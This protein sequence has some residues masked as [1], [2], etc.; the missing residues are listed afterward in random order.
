MTVEDEVILRAGLGMALAVALAALGQ[1]WWGAE[2]ARE[3]PSWMMMGSTAAGVV[4]LFNLA[5]WLRIA[6]RAN[7][8][9]RRAGAGLGW[10]LVGASGAWVALDVSG[11]A[12]S[13]GWVAG[14]ARWSTPAEGGGTAGMKSASALLLF[15]TA[16]AGCWAGAA[17]EGI[18]WR[19]RVGLALSVAAGGFSLAVAIVQAAGADEVF[20][21]LPWLSRFWCAV[22]ILALNLA[23]T[24]ELG[25]WSG[26]ARLALGEAACEESAARRRE[27]RWMILGSLAA[28][29][30]LIALAFSYLDA[31][32]RE[33]REATTRALAS[34]AE[35]QSGALAVWLRERTGDAR[36]LMNSPGLAERL[37]EATDPSRPSGAREVFSRQLEGYRTFYGYAA[38]VVFDAEFRPQ[39]R[40]LD[41]G[42]PVP[43]IDAD[44]QRAVRAA[45]DVVA[46]DIASSG[47]GQVVMDFIVPVRGGSGGFAGAVLLRV[48]ARRS[49]FPFLRSWPEATRTG[50]VMLL[51]REGEVVSV[52]NDL[53][54]GAAA[55][56][57]RVPMS[58]RER[59][60]VQAVSGRRRGLIKA[61]DHRGMPVV[62]LARSVE[63]APW[64]LLVKLD[65][66]EAYAE[67]RHRALEMIGGFGFGSVLL[68]LLL[69]LAW[70]RRERRHL[71]AQIEAERERQAL[72]RRHGLLMQRTTDGILLLDSRMR[73]AEANGRASELYGYGGDG[74]VGLSARDLRAAA[75]GDAAEREFGGALPEEGRVFES[76]HRR[77][78]GT[79]FPVE[80]SSQPVEV[81]GKRRVLCF[82]RDIS[83][84]RAQ[85][86]DLAELGR[87]YRLVSQLNQCMARAKDRRAL[88][89]E[90]CR[91]LVET[92]RF[93]IAWA[94]WFN[95]ATRL[96]DPVAVNGDDHGYVTEVRVSADPDKAEGRGPC[97]CAFRENRTH[98]CNDF[99]FD[100][101][102]GPWRDRARTSGFRSNISLPLRCE[103][104]AVGLLA[105][106][107]SEAGFFDDPKR[108]LLEEVAENLS[109]M[110]GVFAGEGR[111]REAEEALAA[112]E[113]LF[114]SI[115]NQAVDGIVVIDAVTA[116]FI[117][118]NRAAHEG[119]GYSREEF[120]A[121]R[122][123][124]VDA[125]DSPT[126]VREH[127]VSVAA[128]GG[129]VFETRHRHRNGSVRHVR[130]SATFL[131]LLGR[132]CIAALWS[133]VTERRRIEAA[134]RE[135]E[136]RYR[137]LFELETDAILLME[138]GTGAI[139]ATNPAAVALYGYTAEELLRLTGAELS[140][141]P[142]KTREDLRFEPGRLGLVTSVP[143]RRHRKRD[144]TVFPV[145]A[146]M[147]FF[148]R[149]GRHLCLAA[150]RDVS[151]QESARDT[152]KRFN[153]DLEAQV[154]R[155]TAEL[156]ARN[157][158]VQALLDAI[159]DTVLRLRSDGTV[160]SRR[161]AHRS[162]ALAA[163][164]PRAG[165]PGHEGAA[166]RLLAEGFA[167]GRRAT[168][169][170][171]AVTGEAEIST[172]L[173]NLALELR[174]AQT[175]LDE[176]VVFVRDVTARK[177]LEAE[178]AA[179][180]ERER[181]ISEMKTRFI[182][183]TSHEFRTPLTVAM[184]SVELLQ[185]H[186]DRLSPEK[187]DEIFGR[188][189]G[190][191]E[192][193][194]EMLDDVLTLSRFDAGRVDVKPVGLDIG[195]F[196]RELID[197]MRMGDRDA[198]RFA[199]EQAGDGA[200]FFT[201]D[202]LLR[203]VVS[204][205]LS[206]AVRYSPQGS[207][208]TARL[209]VDGKRARFVVEDEG[210]GIPDADRARL[211]QAFERGSNVGTIKGTGLGL[212][213]VKRT[214]EM[215]GGEI[216]VEPGA[217]RGTR[218]V[219]VLPRMARP[220]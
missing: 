162:P 35:V 85:A 189:R 176:F 53:R 216:S 151:L 49:V 219:V 104:R 100:P 37:R 144:G 109:F 160:L 93:R 154:G 220:S 201:D 99:L 111:R 120:A 116:S 113:K 173:G 32:R 28:L 66:R 197:E 150:I 184:G 88:L 110:L 17:G 21:D 25:F 84:R 180:L 39:V 38:V 177:R 107:A 132:N 165:P 169:E 86:R 8:R 59:V 73:I 22:A 71:L 41:A 64:T 43:T 193:L 14:L 82:V 1:G 44:R 175:G 190:A 192:R 155:R 91:V 77:R 185:H 200:D 90:I 11:L 27:R 34:V 218:F 138:A 147:R 23:I 47:R 210:I 135:N 15:A 7:A 42:A 142:D 95:P 149:E 139:V 81:D 129:T 26:L 170:G 196:F 31:L 121:L 92:G 19:R 114:S 36:L 106:Y 206:N 153:A 191:V 62:G 69:G 183:V 70:R 137:D 166:G 5:G 122:L 214:L 46:G 65:R 2:V 130:V 83:V 9:C 79:E 145:E 124:Q 188:I 6:G 51:R 98:V 112:R 103:G 123:D 143:D 4:L 101:L 152:L 148:A 89:V 119:L 131:Q 140:A 203:Q 186:I 58:K 181:Q 72:V 194:T 10:L 13:V 74:L 75:A 146:K 67:V 158:E 126:R 94:G 141:E 40:L 57:L 136:Q 172:P 30:M 24:A 18:S 87:M 3:E 97:G 61:E 198:H 161:P 212:S 29:L 45:G 178:T 134:L 118:F 12:D 174:A 128:T 20:P 171:V 63:G 213:I 68:G 54:F 117:E 96:I 211:F 52:L 209:Q 78:D 207:V 167:L 55:L 33:A 50:E 115:V 168:E 157:R 215:L 182:S 179:M 217:E 56:E 60:V 80:V 102:T 105:V 204:N 16:L 202:G 76:V 125:D 163:I 195:R 208:V 108:A 48:D 133:D 205:L 199:F 127:L 164:T 187:R 159:P 156:A